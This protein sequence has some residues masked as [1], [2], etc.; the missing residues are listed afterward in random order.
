M[1]VGTQFLLGWAACAGVM[2]ALWVRQ[3]RTRDATAVDVAWAANLALL[4]VGFALTGAGDPGRR[5]AVAATAGSAGLRLAWHLWRDRVRG[6]GEDGRYA[7]LR[8]RWGDR[9]GARFFVFFQAQALLDAVLALPFLLAC[10]GERPIG[11]VDLAALAL[12]AIA[13]TGET[14]AD[15]QLARFKAE[16]GNR[17]RTCRAGLWR[18]SRHPN[19]FFEWLCWCAYALLAWS[20]PYGWLGIVSPLSMLFLILRVT[21]IPPTE[22]QALRSRGDDYRSYQRTTS[23]FFPWFPRREAAR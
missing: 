22:A 9:A 12:W 20:A 13:I 4:A 11:P 1:S 15:R 23:A 2:L 6:R 16:P 3:Q 19:Y 18:W 10:A 5:A 21:G 14:L 17:G 7:E 8:A